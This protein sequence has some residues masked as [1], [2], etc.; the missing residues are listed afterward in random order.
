M[1]FGDSQVSQKFPGARGLQ[2]SGAPTLARCLCRQEP[3]PRCGAVAG[4]RGNDS[5]GGGGTVP[6]KHQSL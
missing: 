6:W 3:A 2:R 5:R 1:I 4:D